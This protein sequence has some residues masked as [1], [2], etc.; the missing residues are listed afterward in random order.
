MN[1]SWD[2]TTSGKELRRA[3]E[4]NPN[5]ASVHAT[6]AFYLERVGRLP[7]AIAEAK[8][9]LQLDPVSSRSFTS[10]GIVPG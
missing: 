10:L 7:E 8:R 2:W 4:L 9:I 5:S 6:Y 3:L 1:L